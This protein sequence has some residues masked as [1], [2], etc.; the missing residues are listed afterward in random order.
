MPESSKLL[1]ILFIPLLAIATIPVHA[2]QN[3]GNNDSL[4]AIS[5]DSS[6][7]RYFAALYYTSGLAAD[8]Y[9]VAQPA[10]AC[11]FL[12]KFKDSFAIFF[13]EANKR[14]QQKQPQ[15]PGWQQYYAD[16]SLNTLQYYFLG[17]NAHINGDMWQAL[18]KAHPYDSIRKYRKPFLAFQHSLSR[19]FDT[20]YAGFTNNKKLKRFHVLTL[21]TDKYYGKRMMLQWRKRQ[22]KLA[23]LF[24]SRPAAFKRRLKKNRRRMQ[25]LDHFIIKRF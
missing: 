17:M 15:S 19:L 4:Y 5:K 23:L 12:R 20:I 16:T 9:A 6:I 13:L 11:R 14:Y 8:H 3:A 22:V 10:D 2:Q 7:S 24:Y 25:R 21:G 18:V 1:N